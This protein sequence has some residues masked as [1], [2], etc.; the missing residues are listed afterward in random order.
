MSILVRENIQWLASVGIG[1]LW[2]LLQATDCSD[3]GTLCNSQF[4]SQLAFN[5]CSAI[6]CHLI[7][8]DLDWLL[9]ENVYFIFKILILILSKNILH[10]INFWIFLCCARWKIVCFV[11]HFIWSHSRKMHIHERKE[12]EN[13]KTQLSGFFD[14]SA[15]P[16]SLALWP[17]RSRSAFVSIIQ[18]FNETWPVHSHAVHE[19]CTCW[20][21]T[22]ID[23]KSIHKTC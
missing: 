3:G 10:S 7:C 14:F 9:N 16:D 20:A 17:G 12:E 5:Q 6:S 8:R 21:T 11:N 4:G 13:W 19:Q 22:F 15:S 18:S 2:K 1:N 23:A